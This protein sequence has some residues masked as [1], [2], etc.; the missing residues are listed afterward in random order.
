[1][2]DLAY[3]QDQLHN[4]IE[5]RPDLLAQ[6]GP[7]LL[8]TLLVRATQHCLS[9]AAGLLLFC[10]SFSTASWAG[11]E[12]GSLSIDRSKAP[13]FALPI[14]RNAPANKQQPN[15]TAQLQLSELKGKWVYLDF[16][17]SWCGPCRKSF[18]AMNQW[19]SEWQHLNIV[20]IAVNLDDSETLAQEFLA[21]TPASF[22]ILWDPDWKVADLFGVRGMPTS[23]LI[24]TEGSLVSQH[25]GFSEAKAQRIKADIDALLNATP[26]DSSPSQ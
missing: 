9:Q 20:I 18:P 6:V 22:P 17:A 11:T 19:Y 24:D 4:D 5:Q 15:Q 7:I 26:P 8:L 3:H 14:I 13:E 1:M 10:I 21:E 2:Y 23:F 25:Q 16:W 12:H